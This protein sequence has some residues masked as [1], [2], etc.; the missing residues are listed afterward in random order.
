MRS[1]VDAVCF[2]REKYVMGV[3][4]DNGLRLRI[5]QEQVLGKATLQSPSAFRFAHFHYKDRVRPDS[6]LF[7]RRKDLFYP[8]RLLD[9]LNFAIAI[10]RSVIKVD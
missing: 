4:P 5:R 10:S 6:H 9:L 8:T 2:L 7:E 3:N 1:K